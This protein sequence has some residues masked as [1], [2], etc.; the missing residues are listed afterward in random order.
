[1]RGRQRSRGANRPAGRLVTRGELRAFRRDLT[2][3]KTVPP[4]VPTTFVQVPW[5]SWTF[6]RVASS[7]GAGSFS[8][9][10][11]Q[12]VIDQIVNRIGIRDTDPK[13]QVR[14]KVQTAQAY[15]TADGLTNPDVETQFFELSGQAVGVDQYPRSIQRDKGTL[16]MPA[17]TGFTYSLADRR[18]ILGASE[19][20]LK[21]LK[22][23][24]QVG[25][26]SVVTTRVHV[27]WCSTPI[28]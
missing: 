7:T 20:T 10:T 6:E 2:G 8:E 15:V 9:I 1:M 12:D 13:A 18:E 19:G 16:N 23:T 14:I 25:S 11:V 21:I 22:A 5:N 17:R 26:G 24:D 4:P 27:L 28:Q 3:H